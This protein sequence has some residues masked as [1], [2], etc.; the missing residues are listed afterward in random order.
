MITTELA[1]VFVQ[2]RPDRAV[3]YGALCR[4]ETEC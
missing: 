2:M 1:V 3:I 4:T